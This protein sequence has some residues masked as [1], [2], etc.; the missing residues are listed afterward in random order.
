MTKA[1]FHRTTSTINGSECEQLPFTTSPSNCYSVPHRWWHDMVCT[2]CSSACVLTCPCVC[3]SADILLHDMRHL[4]NYWVITRWKQKSRFDTPC[5]CVCVCVR[6]RSCLYLIVNNDNDQ[7]KLV[8]IC[9]Y[10]KMMQHSD[11]AASNSAHWVEWELQQ[12]PNYYNG[13]WF[14]HVSDN[15]LL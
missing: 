7:V 14:N 6:C 8:P 15:F 1:N 10:T 4:A 13:L 9:S 3:M 2:L 5:V 11:A 12:S